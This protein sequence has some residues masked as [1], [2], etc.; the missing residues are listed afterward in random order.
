M[1]R[2]LLDPDPGDANRAGVSLTLEQG[3]LQARPDGKAAFGL[4]AGIKSA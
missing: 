2:Y 1:E 3:K 4:L